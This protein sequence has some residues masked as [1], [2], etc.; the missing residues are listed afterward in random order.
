MR[1]GR[2][3]PHFVLS[4]SERT[5]L[6]QYARRPTTAQALALRARIVLRCATGATHTDIA[7]DLGV[8][9]QTVG[10]WRTRFA[11]T[12]IAG[13][14]D[15]PRPGAPRKITDAQI[16]RAIATTLESTP[17]DAT[18]WSTRDLAKH[19]GLSQSTV[20]RMWKAFALQPHRMETFKLSKDP[21]FIDKV[22]DIVGLYLHPP[23][24]ALVLC[25]D[26]KSQIQA[27]D[28]TA[29]LLPMRPG[30]PARRTH[31]YVRHGTTSLFAALDV[32]AGTVIGACHARHRAQE[33]RQFLQ[34]IEAA[35]P[36][37]LDVHLILDNYATHK[38][39]AIHRWLL[40]HPRFH[41]HF[42]PTSASWLNLVERWFV[43][44]TRKQI[45]RGT[46][47]STKAL[48]DAITGYIALN[49]DAPKPFVWSKTA[50]QILDSV[51]RFCTRISESRH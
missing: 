8:T 29:P 18:H 25:V 27:L 1:R 28:R 6:E 9:K 23:D 38:T 13:L 50:D 24:R 4:P 15:S 43:E 36:S 19:E 21:L 47:R 12:R 32:K 49:N 51:A 45:K 22:R 5:T 41:L 2:P 10:K 30:L 7:A 40:R 33:F 26:E 34:R 16:E 46:H 42:T 17:R 11:A 37:D 3:V 35:V 44:L 48:R 14:L 39:P 31:D 20:A